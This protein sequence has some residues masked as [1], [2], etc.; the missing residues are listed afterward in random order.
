MTPEELAILKANIK[1]A[2]DAYKRL[3]TG[4]S[5][6]EWRDQNGE[7]VKYTRMNRDGLRMYI[8]ELKSQLPPAD[9]AKPVWP[10]PLRPFF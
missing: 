8:L 5:A 10:T 2:E 7:S 4:Q 3:M 9:C 1:D 6:E